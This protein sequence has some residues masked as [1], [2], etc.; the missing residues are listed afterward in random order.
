LL[1]ATALLLLLSDV[2]SLT[3]VPDCDTLEIADAVTNEALDIDSVSI[4]TLF[5]VADVIAMPL[6]LPVDF[7]ATV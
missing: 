5:F 7:E 4:A 6:E 3:A 1:D 2:V